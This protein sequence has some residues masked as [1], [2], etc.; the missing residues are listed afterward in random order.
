MWMNPTI[1]A[2]ENPSLRSGFMAWRWRVIRR[3]VGPPIEKEVQ[4]GPM[5]IL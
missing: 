5:E 2:H 1:A 4:D 3:A